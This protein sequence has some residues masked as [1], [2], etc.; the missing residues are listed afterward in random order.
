MF[1]LFII[2]DGIKDG[3]LYARE[4]KHPEWYTTEKLEAEMVRCGYDSSEHFLASLDSMM[5]RKKWIG[6][7]WI[8]FVRQFDTGKADEYATYREDL[9]RLREEQE[10]QRAVEQ[11]AKDEAE[12]K[13]A[14]EALQAEKAKYMGWADGMTNMR[15]G[16]VSS[17]MERLTRVDGKVMTKREFI[18]G[19]VKDGWTPSERK[20]VVSYYGS[21]WEPKQSKPRTEYLMCRN[22]RCY[23]VNKTEYEFAVYL[24]SRNEQEVKESA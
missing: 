2:F 9:L 8:E 13:A 21:R 24:V 14:E 5:D 19:L 16:R 20:D 3:I 10:Q 1:D 6:N 18:L 4:M 15:F 17:I 11:Q 7:V 22:N 23:T 12:R